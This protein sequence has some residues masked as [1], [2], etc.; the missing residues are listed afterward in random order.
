MQVEPNQEIYIFYIFLLLIQS[1]HG[2]VWLRTE[3]QAYSVCHFELVA[4]PPNSAMQKIHL[5]GVNRE[6]V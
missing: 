2:E 1:I 4:H 3:Q 6:V 5:N